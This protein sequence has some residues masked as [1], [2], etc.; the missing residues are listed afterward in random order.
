MTRM[1]LN[2]QPSAEQT[3]SYPAVPSA[4]IAFTWLLHLRWGA[5]F[6]QALLV[7]AVYFFFE[8]ELPFLI[9]FLIFA[10]EGA[11]NIVFSCLSR[12]KANIDDRLFIIVMCL[13]ILLMTVLLHLT[14]GPMNPFTFL[15]L[16]HIALG[17]VL[18]QPQWAFGLAGFT[19]V[20]YATLFFLPAFE[21]TDIPVCHFP[22]AAGVLADDPLRLHLQGMWLAFTITVFFVVFFIGKIQQALVKNQEILAALEKERVNGERLASLATLSAGAAHE[23]STPLSTIALAAGEMLHAMR[24]NH[25]QGDLYED[26]VLIREQVT[27][28]KDILFQMAADAGNQLGEGQESCTLR[29]LLQY[30]LSHFNEHE[31]QQISMD[32]HSPEF[33]MYIPKRTF[34]RV[35]RGIIKNS[36]DASPQ[37]SA[38]RVICR[39][40][41]NHLRIIVSD[42]G[43]G[44]NEEHRSRACE[45]FYTTKEPGKGMGLGLYLAKSAMER[46]DGQ[47]DIESSPGV[48]TTVTLSFGRDRIK[49]PGKPGLT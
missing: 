10:F 38:V 39:L 24:K 41:A 4:R 23:F 6:A 25:I 47:L 34:G 44:M 12:K 17:S 28:C 13:D 16:V 27:R 8:S 45:P 18:L 5:V 3:K 48:G 37:G 7:L 46:F 40:E 35:I 1:P 29:E 36:L 14:G 9:V 49:P 22:A 20:N 21:A 19:V 32:N 26:A 42:S 33:R 30:A 15:Y 31:R 43:S 11:S 2:P